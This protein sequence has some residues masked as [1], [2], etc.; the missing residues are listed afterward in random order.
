MNNSTAQTLLQQEHIIDEPFA[1]FPGKSIFEAEP[2]FLSVNIPSDTEEIKQDIEDIRGKNTL[3]IDL[4]SLI[5]GELPFLWEYRFNS[6]FATEIGAGIILPYYVNLHYLF[7]KGVDKQDP[8]RFDNH[9]WGYS[10]W[11]GIRFYPIAR[12]WDTNFYL[13][14]GAHYRGFA[15]IHVLDIGAGAGYKFQIKRFMIDLGGN[16]LSFVQ[17]S[18]DG[19]TYFYP[20]STQS[21]QVVKFGFSFTLKVGVI[22]N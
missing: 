7:Y 17:E 21:K 19:Q 3:S 22:L 11:A 14:L 1:L 18:K 4:V 2:T 6:L 8:I 9:H 5:R 15:K 16:V 20:P 12:I 10:F 13:S